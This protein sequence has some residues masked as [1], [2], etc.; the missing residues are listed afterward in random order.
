MKNNERLEVYS[1]IESD[2]ENGN[3]Y[4]HRIGCAFI[5]KDGSINGYFNSL[6]L[7]GKFHMRRRTQKQEK[8]GGEQ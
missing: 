6:P 3:A 2:S 5:N 7:D 8:Q 4:W 1:I